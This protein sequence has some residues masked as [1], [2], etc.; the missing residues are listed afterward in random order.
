MFFDPE[1][2][3]RKQK[4]KELIENQKNRKNLLRDTASTKINSITA[5]TSLMTVK[6][7]NQRTNLFA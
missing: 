5:Q 1:E 3:R 4:E 2:E 7:V 6:Q